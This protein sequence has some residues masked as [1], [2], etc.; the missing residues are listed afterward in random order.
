MWCGV[1]QAASALEAGSVRGDAIGEEGEFED[2]DNDD[3]GASS[4][5][6]ASAP[7][8]AGNMA[9]GTWASHRAASISEDRWRPS[10]DQ[11]VKEDTRDLGGLHGGGGDGGA[12]VAA[13]NAPPSST[14][15]PALTAP[16]TEATAAE[17]ATAIPAYVE[18]AT[19][20]WRQC[21]VPL[22]VELMRMLKNIIGAVLA[23]PTFELVW[24]LLLVFAI[25][26]LQI[27]PTAFT[28]ASLWPGK[29]ARSEL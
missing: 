23:S 9:G 2:D 29:S 4:Y 13:K 25:L 3:D 22:A 24:P 27:G 19:T 7:V 8:F 15:P 12:N 14:Q 5:S 21:V 1:A 10:L 11:L 16:S 17:T 20:M 28:P 18:F 26:R 6:R